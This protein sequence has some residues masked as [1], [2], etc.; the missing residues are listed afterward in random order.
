MDLNNELKEEYDR[1]GPW[2]FEISE[3][4]PLPRLFRP[5]IKSEETPLLSIKIPR[6]IERRDARPGMHLYNYVVNLYEKDILI[7]KREGD[8]VLSFMYPYNQIQCIC[9]REELL[10]GNLQLKMTDGIYKL[11]YSNVSVKVI[12]K[13]IDQIRHRYAD[14][15]RIPVKNS[16]KTEDI[17]SLSF[18]FSGLLNKEA[19]RNP[20]FRPIASQNETSIAFS[21]RGFFRK[22][23][24]GLVG[25][26]MLESLHMTDGRELMVINRG[27][28]FRRRS[29]AVYSK[30][31]FYVP[32]KK[33]KDISLYD[34]QQN[35]AVLNQDLVT[36][37]NSYHLVFLKDNETVSSY[38]KINFDRSMA[39]VLKE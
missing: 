4:H 29:E 24:S 32:M 21:E 9:H 5:F 7:L 11:P 19:V 12:H 38:K 14:E 28:S 27:Q 35:T 17:E 25:K 26:R 37:N 15:A 39:S 34:D 8:D 36:S 20:G 10:Y 6:D 22:L 16:L 18:Y 23:K 3:N 33:L 30:E 1:F 31:T 2:V 13:L